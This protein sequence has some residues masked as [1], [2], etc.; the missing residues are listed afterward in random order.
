MSKIV[1][2]N[3]SVDRHTESQQ[4]K[5]GVVSFLKK[6]KRMTVISRLPA[7]IIGALTPREHSFI[8]VDEE[9]EDIDFDHTDA[10]LI[11]ITAMTCQSKRAFEIAD[12]FRR[13]GIKVVIG[14]IHVSVIPDSAEGHADAI[15]IGQ[16]EN[17]WPDILKDFEA[18]TLKPRY[19][20]KDYPPVTVQTSPRVDIVKHDQYVYFP[21]MATRGCPNECE[22]CSIKHSSGHIVRYKP[23]EQIMAEVA[24]LEKYNTETL[25]KR[26]QFMDD[27]LYINKE[28]TKQLFTA[29]KSANIQWVGQGTLNTALDEEMVKLMAES[30]CKMYFI[31]FESITETSLKEANKLKSNKVED[32]EKAIK[33]LNKHGIISAGYFIVGFDGDDKAVFKDTL[34]FIKEKRVINALVG[35]LTPL[36]GT[37]LYERVV[38]RIFDHRWEHFTCLRSLFTPNQMTVEELTAGYIWINKEVRRLEL[39]KT[40]FD[41]FWSQGPW[42]TNP[43]IKLWERVVLFLLGIQLRGKKEYREHSDFLIW[44]AKHKNAVDVMA[45]LGAVAYCDQMTISYDYN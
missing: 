17:V 32:Y 24:D 25:K 4:W 9:I 22:F 23:V 30:G 26:Y 38:E 8:F 42:P 11:A 7:M 28:Y 3:P 36:P 44:A 31:G 29:L 13:R 35:I 16:G 27:N 1:F 34:A 40:Q 20:A 18:G 5:F 2:I 19:E 43:R 45:I 6:G 39:V 37:K 41:Y 14:G 15:C 33:N 21:L 12:E 10:D